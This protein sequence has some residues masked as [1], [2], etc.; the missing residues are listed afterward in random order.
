[1]TLAPFHDGRVELSH[2]YEFILNRPGGN[3]AARDGAS[4]KPVLVHFAT[5]KRQ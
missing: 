1:M 2:E 3:F 5:A 4:L